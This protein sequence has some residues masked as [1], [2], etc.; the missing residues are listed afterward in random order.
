SDSKN[1]LFVFSSQDQQRRD[2]DLFE[3]ALRARVPEH[4]NFHTSYVDYERM[5]DTSYRESLAETFR[6]AY[7][8]VKL[9]VAVVSSIEAFQFV[10]D[11][12]NKILPGVPIVFYALSPKELEGQR[13]PSGVT[14][15]TGDVGLRETIEL[16][17]HLHPD[18]Q[19]VAVVTETPGFWWKVAQTELYRH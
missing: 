16:A 11:Y 1:V 3:T 8:N 17:L 7:K 18:A 15:R 12:R 2:L 13:I 19:A 5:G 4:L 6:I 10:T 14:G 9:D